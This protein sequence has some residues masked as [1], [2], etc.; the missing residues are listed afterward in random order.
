[1]LV[2]GATGE[3]NIC[4]NNIPYRLYTK[5]DNFHNEKRYS[6][7]KQKWRIKYVSSKLIALQRPA[8][9]KGNTRQSLYFVLTNVPVRDEFHLCAVN[10]TK[11]CPVPKNT[12]SLAVNP[13]IW[14]ES[15]RAPSFVLLL[16]DFVL[17]NVLSIE[18]VLLRTGWKVLSYE[19]ILM[20][21][22]WYTKDAQAKL[23]RTD[24]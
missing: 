20:Y 22:A 7:W 3:L 14:H 19:Y 10:Q 9:F 24:T 18:D 2:K 6:A 17:M 1:M 16:R 21:S 5:N 23:I 11:S 15:H 13:F 4:R 12:T 8:Y